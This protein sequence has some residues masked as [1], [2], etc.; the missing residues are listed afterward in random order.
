ML[1]SL[2][3]HSAFVKLSSKGSSFIF[4]FIDGFLDFDLYIYYGVYDETII[5]LLAHSLIN[6][7][8]LLKSTSYAYPRSIKQG[9]QLDDSSMIM[10]EMALLTQFP[11][12]DLCQL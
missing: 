5:I 1:I 8:F 12:N 9:E 4:D 3:G 11:V 7:H 10:T 6:N 2:H